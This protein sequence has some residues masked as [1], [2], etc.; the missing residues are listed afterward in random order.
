MSLKSLKS[1]LVERIFIFQTIFFAKIFKIKPQT[2]HS[3][4][5]IYQ[6]THCK[7]QDD[8]IPTRNEENWNRNMANSWMKAPLCII[9]R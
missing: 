9:I 8:Q 1:D 6:I 3:S 2:P 5:F 7:K 4:V